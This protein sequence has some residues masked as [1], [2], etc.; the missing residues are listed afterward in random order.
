MDQSDAQRWADAG[1]QALQQNQTDQQQQLRLSMMGAYAANPD[2]EAQAR[3]LAA[4]AR[5]PLDTARNLPDEVKVQAQT[6]AFDA[7]ALQQRFPNTARWLAVPDN[8]RL[9]HDDI[10]ATTAV[11]QHVTAL[12]S[13]GPYSWDG[14]S[15]TQ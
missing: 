4:A 8:A 9:A 7:A 2:Q 15:M 1:T 14:T 12:G 13:G 11:E 6:S 3:R 10:P 5:V